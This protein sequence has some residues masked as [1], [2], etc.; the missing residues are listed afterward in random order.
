V[1]ERHHVAVVGALRMNCLEKIALQCVV[2][3]KILQGIP[4]LPCARARRAHASDTGRW[5]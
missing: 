4:L 5:N 3:T 2:C 1:K